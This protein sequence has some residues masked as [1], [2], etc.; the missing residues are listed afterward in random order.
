MNSGKEN[1]NKYI[2]TWY[3]DGKLKKRDTGK[4][5]PAVQAENIV[6]EKKSFNIYGLDQTVWRKSYKI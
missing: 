6:S 2:Q 5:E 4:N 3:L 1:S